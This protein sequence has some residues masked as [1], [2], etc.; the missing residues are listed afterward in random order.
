MTK[1][2]HEIIV[3]PF[4]WS[5]DLSLVLSLR[6]TENQE[7][8][9]YSP[10]THHLLREVRRHPNFGSKVF[11]VCPRKQSGER[12]AGVFLLEPLTPTSNTRC[13]LKGLLIDASFQNCGIGTLVMS[14]L[15]KLVLSEFPGSRYLH[16][17]VHKENKVASN[18]Y[19]RWGFLKTG[20][21][22][23]VGTSSR[24]DVEYVLEIS[25]SQHD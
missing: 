8:H 6:M 21:E 23:P 4:D 2:I 20:N 3:R 12:V 24:H 13:V 19:E 1:R 10:T 25:R 16:L 17:T 14:K 22:I 7:R 11:V 18:L 5:R 15:P 9:D